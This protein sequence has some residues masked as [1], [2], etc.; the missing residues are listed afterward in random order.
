[1]LD[2]APLSQAARISDAAEEAV[3]LRMD[4]PRLASVTAGPDSALYLA[5]LNLATETKFS[6]TLRLGA[7]QFFS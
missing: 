1:M 6:A 2:E 3:A 4:F 5:F 7:L